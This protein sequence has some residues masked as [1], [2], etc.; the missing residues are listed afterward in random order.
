MAEQPGGSVKLTPVRAL[1][2]AALFGGLAGWLLVVTA[3]AFD[4]IPP[5]VPWTAPIGLVLLAALVGALAYSSHQRIQVRRERMEPSRAVAFLV[6]GK[7]SALAG[8]LVAGGYFGFALMFL[9]RI[10]AVAPR[11]RVIRSGI[12]VLAGVALCVAGLLLERACK[13]PGEDDDDD[14]LESDTPR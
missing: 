2:V 8:A 10:D 4:L 14:R 12:A 7:A 1:V 13:I 3:N 9:T 6:L 5:E 11:D